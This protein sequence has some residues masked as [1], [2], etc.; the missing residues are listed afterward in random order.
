MRILLLTQYYAPEQVGA[1]IWIRQ[2]ATD[3]V[4]R[5]HAVTVLTAFPNYPDGRVAER[6][7]G[8]WFQT[9]WI[10]GVRV[11]RSYIYATTKRGFWPRAWSFGSFCASALGRGLALRGGFE[12]VYAI[13]PPLAL[14]VT[15]AGIAR[16]QGARLVT[17]VQDLYPYIAVATGYLRNRTAIRFFE[18][19][20][21][22]IYRRS[23]GR[24]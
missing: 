17:N 24:I 16:A 22:W 1:A 2:L 12:A 11:V 5:G 19:M 4:S 20:E 23:P 21:R 18:A 14:G 8:R 10:E 13:L 3:L 15:A 7:R 6:Y 9:E